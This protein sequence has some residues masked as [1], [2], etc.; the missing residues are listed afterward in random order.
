MTQNIKP[1]LSVRTKSG[2]MHVREGEPFTLPDVDDSRSWEVVFLEQGANTSLNGVTRALRQKGRIQ[3][4]RL[5]V[6]AIRCTDL[7]A[8]PVSETTSHI[9]TIGSIDVG[10]RG[11]GRTRIASVLEDL[12]RLDATISRILEFNSRPR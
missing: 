6:N 5:Q 2:I 1:I 10:S 4:D 7:K 12:R 11:E 8:D 9:I 3:S